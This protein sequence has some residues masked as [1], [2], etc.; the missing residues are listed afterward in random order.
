MINN[1]RA[2]SLQDMHRPICMHRYYAQI[3]VLSCSADSSAALQGSGGVAT[4]E[5][6]KHL[7]SKSEVVQLEGVLLVFL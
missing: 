3:L 1:S 5:F 2:G 4:P 7:S 6:Q